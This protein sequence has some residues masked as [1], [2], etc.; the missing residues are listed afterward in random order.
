MWRWD[1]NYNRDYVL[2]DSLDKKV[3]FEK[4]HFLF[5]TISLVIVCL[6]LLVVIFISCD[7]TKQNI[8]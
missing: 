3:V 2:I 1:S 6:F 4:D 5:H 8:G 7:Y